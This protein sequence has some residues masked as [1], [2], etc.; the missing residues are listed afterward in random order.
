MGV[1][2]LYAAAAPQY[3]FTD[4]T[5]K[6]YNSDTMKGTTMVVYIGSHW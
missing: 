5:G 4:L 6:T 3:S 2:Q 1:S